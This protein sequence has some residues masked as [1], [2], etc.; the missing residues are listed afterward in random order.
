MERSCSI[1]MGELRLN[2]VCVDRGSFDADLLLITER[3]GRGMSEQS[4]SLTS[5]YRRSTASEEWRTTVQLQLSSQSGLKIPYSSM[6]WTTQHW[7][8][9][10]STS[11]SAHARSRPKAGPN[12]VSKMHHLSVR[13]EVG[14]ERH[15]TL[16]G[17]IA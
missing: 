13:K 4:T 14:G 12:D 5:P 11:Q 2:V 6:I 3:H 17:L 1:W 7:S 16:M 15:S 10:C 8:P 9:M